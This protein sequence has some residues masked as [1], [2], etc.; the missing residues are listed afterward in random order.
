[1]G[2]RALDKTRRTS[3]QRLE[4]RR[5]FVRNLVDAG[6]PRVVRGPMEA[7]SGGGRFERKYLP[8]I[9]ER[10]GKLTVTGYISTGTGRGLHGVLVRCDC[11]EREYVIE[12]NNFKNKLATRCDVCAKSANWKKRYWKYAEIL[13]DDEHRR[14]LLNRLAAAIT[15]CHSPTAKQYHAYGGRG[16]R[17]CDEWRKD[18]TAF[19]R[20]V[21]TC[22]GWDDPVLEMDRAD[23]SQGYEPGN[24]RFLTKRANNQ[25]RRTIPALEAECA[26]LRSHVSW[27]EAQIF[28]ME[29]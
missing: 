22:P 7:S 16:I 8:S 9:G 18:R 10:S 21:Q 27:L 15:R 19:L 28:G 2:R 13:P 23:N 17:V 12:S 3:V 26:R 5:E 14:R 11:D 25:N 1:M 6:S 24:I 20:H 29:R 4:T